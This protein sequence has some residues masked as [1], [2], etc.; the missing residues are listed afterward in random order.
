MDKNRK[1]STLF[2][3]NLPHQSAQ[4]GTVFDY[5]KSFQ[6]YS[7]HEIFELNMLS[8]FPEKI[9]LKRFDVVV[10]HYTLSIGPL[11][12]HYFDRNF[13]E[14]FKNFSGLKVVFFQDEY[15]NIDC[16]QAHLVEYGFDLLFTIV[17]EKEIEKVYPTAKLP[18]LKKINVLTGYVPDSWDSEKYF[19]DISNRP[20]D[21]GYRS[22]AMPFWLGKLGHEKISVMR[23]IKNHR[24]SKNLVLDMSVNEGDRLYGE[25]WKIFLSS[26]KAVLGTESGAKIVDFSGDLEKTVDE[27]VY[28]NPNITFEQVYDKFLSVY[29]NNVK[30][31]QISPRCFEAAMLKVPMILVEGD[32]SGIL[33]KNEH[34]IELKK[35]LSNIEEVCKNLSNIAY[36]EKI[37]KIAY[38]DLISSGIYSYAKFIEKFDFELDQLAMTAAEFKTAEPYTIKEFKRDYFWSLRF[39]FL[40][41]MSL[42]FNRLVMGNRLGRNAIFMLWNSAPVSFRRFLRPLTKIISK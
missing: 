33:R 23:A 6:K 1:L 20:I 8:R 29:E 5:V 15:R 39:R 14:Q 2:L 11:I 3:F 30:L 17:P 18:K 31:A 26:C 4:A 24:S 25:N 40:R 7:K 41:F 13:L 28:K 36:L 21:L 35:D 10:I 27:Y 9:C 42:Y 38:E 19:V 37:S 22:R 16:Y 32:Y 12:N 34:Y